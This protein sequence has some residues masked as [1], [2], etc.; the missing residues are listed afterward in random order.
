MDLS[1]LRLPGLEGRV[2]V[3]T[4]HRGGIGSAVAA[5]LQAQ[6]CRVVGLDLPDI[7]LGNSA[8][9]EARAQQVVA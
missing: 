7:D 1:A 5:M 3:V 2:A 8:G 6:G 4:G 9:L